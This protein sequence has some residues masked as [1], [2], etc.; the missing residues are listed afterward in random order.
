[1]GGQTRVG[2]NTLRRC[3]SASWSDIRD[4]MIKLERESH[5][6]LLDKIGACSRDSGEVEIAKY[7]SYLRRATI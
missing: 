4:A 5:A 7:S 6:A 2:G 1:M 3:A